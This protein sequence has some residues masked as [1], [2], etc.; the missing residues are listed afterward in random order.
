MVNRQYADEFDVGRA[1]AAIL[2]L[3]VEPLP[4]Q[5]PSVVEED[6]LTGERTQE[7]GEGF[8]LAPLWQS[9]HLTGV[10]GEDWNAAVRGADR[11]AGEVADELTRRWGPS[12]RVAMHG[13][14]FRYQAGE[15]LPPL[16]QA[17]CDA[18]DYGDLTVWGPV[19]E[20]P[21]GADRWVGI[22]VGQSDGD[23][24]LVLMAAISDREIVEVAGE[25][26]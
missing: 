14:L 17:L 23:A 10:H 26:R 11:R 22:S 5:G 13:A 24:P 4:A 15:P 21:G 9:R 1:V 3:L 16:H 25:P 7:T 6:P 12:R 8:V 20:G 2:A 18:D 19:Q